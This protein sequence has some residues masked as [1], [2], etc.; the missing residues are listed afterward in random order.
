[1]VMYGILELS[2]C[3][4]RKIHSAFSAYKLLNDIK[5]ANV[6]EEIN[7]SSVRKFDTNVYHSAG[8]TRGLN[9]ALYSQRG[10]VAL[11]LEIREAQAQEVLVVP[12][13]ALVVLEQQLVLCALRSYLQIRDVLCWV[14]PELL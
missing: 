12:A 1:M 13:L 11:A 3:F 8:R 6:F 7:S 14:P 9:A 2:K 5:I 10:A 4:K